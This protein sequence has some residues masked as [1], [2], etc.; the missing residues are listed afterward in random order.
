MQSGP[1]EVRAADVHII[2]ASPEVLAILGR[3]L[4]Q[5]PPRLRLVFAARRGLPPAAIPHLR[6]EGQVLSLTDLR[7][8]ADE[9]AALFSD[10]PDQSLD[11]GQAAGLVRLFLRQGELDQAGVGA[12]EILSHLEAT[13]LAGAGR[14]IQTRDNC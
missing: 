13:T 8:I 4:S 7:F 12:E 2:D 11:A 6:T 14:E 5:A 3:L 10:V 9:V 1:A